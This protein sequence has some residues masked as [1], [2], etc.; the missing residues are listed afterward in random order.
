MDIIIAVISAVLIAQII[1]GRLAIVVVG[2]VFVGRRIYLHKRRLAEFEKLGINPENLAEI[3][4]SFNSDGRASALEKIENLQLKNR[5]DHSPKGID[6]GLIVPEVGREIQWS[7][8]VRQVFRVL[9]FDRSGVVSFEGDVIEP[10]NSSSPLGYLLVESP[11]LN[12]P[13]RL[14][15]THSDDFRLAASAFDHPKWNEIHSKNELLVS[16]APRF[17]LP[18]GIAGIWHANH[19]VVVPKGTLERYYSMNDDEN[20]ARPNP[21]MIFGNFVWVGEVRVRFNLNPEL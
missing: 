1:D 8:I 12:Q 6:V 16:Y 7:Q 20:M 15:L 13:M 5:E 2:L 9:E 17:K 21:E 11:I 18:G 3:A 19:Y 14:P 10:T 4:K